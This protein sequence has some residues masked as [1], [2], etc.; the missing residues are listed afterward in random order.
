MNDQA[1]YLLL[2]DTARPERALAAFREGLRL[3]PESFRPQERARFERAEVIY[4]LATGDEA[5]ARQLLTRLLG[6]GGTAE[7][8]NQSLGF[9]YVELCQRFMLLRPE[10]RPGRFKEWLQQALM[11]AANQPEPL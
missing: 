5:A 10:G 2:G 9:A 4:L 7:G 11:L 8:L 1:E 6:S 3:W